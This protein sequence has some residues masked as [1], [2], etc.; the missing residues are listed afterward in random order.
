M[1]RKLLAAL[2]LAGSSLGGCVGLFPPGAE[3]MAKLPVVRY[4]EAAP[5]GGEYVRLYPAGVPL[6]VVAGV[7]GT[8]LTKP[9]QARLEVATNRDIYVYRTWVSFDG[10]TWQAG[11]KVMDA[12]FEMKLPGETDTKAPGALTAQFDLKP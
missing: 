11:D 7:S 9:A 10:K 8:V 4:G 2:V 5:A 12:R 6:P 3:D 1:K